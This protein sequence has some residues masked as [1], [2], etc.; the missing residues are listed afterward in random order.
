MPPPA[1]I[2]AAFSHLEQA[3]GGHLA[4]FNL[5]PLVALAIA[6]PGWR[7][8][9]RGKML[10]IGIPLLFL[11]HVLDLVAHFPMYFHGSGIAQFVV[12]FP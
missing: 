7:L 3:G 5:V 6:I 9:E 8:R 1:L 11:L 10:A 4:N 12:Y 2:K